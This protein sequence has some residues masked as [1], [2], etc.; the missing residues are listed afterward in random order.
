MKKF[1]TLIF[2]VI[3]VICSILIVNQMLSSPQKRYNVM[4]LS[5]KKSYPV[6]TTN[7]VA[8]NNPATTSSPDSTLTP[9]SSIY[10]SNLYSDSTSS[11]NPNP[12]PD[13]NSNM[14]PIKSTLAPSISKS[15]NAS[16]YR[17]SKF[18]YYE[19]RNI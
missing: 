5:S 9:A 12:D 15:V 13:E 11:S 19:V 1:F 8:L 16:N 7:P 2:I 17:C 10:Y 6:N 4:N 18:I 3:I 14:S